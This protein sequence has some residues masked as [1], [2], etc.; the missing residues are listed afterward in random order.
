[1]EG[2][3]PLV[4]KPSNI[5]QLA[6]SPD[7]RFIPSNY[8]HDSSYNNNSSATHDS[9]SIPIVDFSLLISHDS[10]QRST[11]V[12]HLTKACQDWGFFMVRIYYD[13]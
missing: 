13:D 9:N 1:M 2:T 7:F 4:V 8:V 11:A 12:Q 10:H 5:K 3:A 6:E